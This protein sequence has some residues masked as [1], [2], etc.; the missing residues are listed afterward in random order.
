[1]TRSSDPQTV[2]VDF[3]QNRIDMSVS[4]ACICGITIYVSRVDASVM[5]YQYAWGLH[6][7]YL[8]NIAACSSSNTVWVCDP[9]DD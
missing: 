9:Q 7:E 8:V 2:Q 3:L 4:G 5:I 1:M 6:Q